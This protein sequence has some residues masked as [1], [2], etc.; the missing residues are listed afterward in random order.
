M[1]CPGDNIKGSSV[2]NL[3]ILLEASTG[4]E[5]VYT[6]L[7]SRKRG[8]KNKGLVVQNTPRQ[9]V[10]KKR[11]FQSQIRRFKTKKAPS[12]RQL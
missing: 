11:K 2:F 5:P 9:K 3:L 10:N 8:S 7:Q 1:R 12:Q 6:D 4:I